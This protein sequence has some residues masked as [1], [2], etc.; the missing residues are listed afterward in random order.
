M[1]MPLRVIA[2]SMM[3]S[4]FIRVNN[5]TLKRKIGKYNLSHMW[6]RVLFTSPELEVK[7]QKGPQEGPKAQHYTSVIYSRRYCEV[8]DFSAD[9]MKPAYRNGESLSQKVS[10]S[11]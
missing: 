7:N 10:F 9:L 1:K 5:P 8:E 11:V 4:I 2:R 6:D 3:D